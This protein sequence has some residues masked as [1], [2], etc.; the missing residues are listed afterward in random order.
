MLTSPGQVAG[1]SSFSLLCFL[2]SWDGIRSAQ[3]LFSF[4]TLVPH[5]PLPWTCLMISVCSDSEHHTLVLYEDVDSAPPSVVACLVLWAFLRD[6]K[7]GPQGSHD[8]GNWSHLCTKPLPRSGK[9]SLERVS[10]LMVFAF[11]GLFFCHL[12]NIAFHIQSEYIVY[13]YILYKWNILYILIHNIKIHFY[14]I[15]FQ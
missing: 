2:P 14:C 15:L 7:S 1:G 9:P 5:W 6:H 8:L 3:S 11:H 13:I 12:F 10:T 4:C